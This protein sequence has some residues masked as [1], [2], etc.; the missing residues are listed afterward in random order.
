MRLVMTRFH[1]YSYCR[2]SAGCGKCNKHNMITIDTNAINTTA[3]NT[4]ATKQP[5]HWVVRILFGVHLP[6]LVFGAY[7]EPLGPS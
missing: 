6:A 2:D 1:T 4:N 7:W 5:L 3:I